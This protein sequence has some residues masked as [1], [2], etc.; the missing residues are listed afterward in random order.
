MGGGPSCAMGQRLEMVAGG[1]RGLLPQRHWGWH[2][3]PLSLSQGWSCCS[4][5]PDVG[6]CIFL[7]SLLTGPLLTG[8]QGALRTLMES[9]SYVADS[10]KAVREG[11]QELRRRRAALEAATSYRHTMRRA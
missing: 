11:I 6:P 5:F 4:R 3:A 1:G 7:T 9:S 2:L 10:I 8:P